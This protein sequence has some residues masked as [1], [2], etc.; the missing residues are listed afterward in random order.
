MAV[1]KGSR[2]RAQ[3]DSGRQRDSLKALEQTVEG[4]A[5][6]LHGERRLA[7]GVVVFRAGAD[8]PSFAMRAT[9]AGVRIESGGD[10]SDVRLEVI[11]DP[12]R[13]DAIVRG[14]KDARMQ[15][16]AGG[17]RVRGDMFY[18]SEIGL[19]LGFLKTPLF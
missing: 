5:R 7:H 18:L 10:Y 14:R 12:R 16:F 13:I 4:V 15:F 19:E 6:R 2:S 3:N 9:E 1:R 8:G 11:G 17:I